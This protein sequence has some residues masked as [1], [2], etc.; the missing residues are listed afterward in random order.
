MDF[1]ERIFHVAPDGGTGSLELAI[2]FVLLAF[3]IAVALLRGAR[4]S[5]DRSHRTPGAKHLIFS[6]LIANSLV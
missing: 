2:I 5:L 6:R 1:V 3:P 4:A